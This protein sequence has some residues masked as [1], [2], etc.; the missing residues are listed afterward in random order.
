MVAYNFNSEFED[1]IVNGRKR[2]RI[3]LI[4]C[5]RVMLDEISMPEITRDSLAIT[6][7]FG[8]RGDESIDWE[9]VN[10]AIIERWSLSALEYIKR[11]AWNMLEVKA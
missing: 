1:A 9:K 7:A 11:K 3:Q 5:E 4:D 8:L 2:M 10:H 6:Y